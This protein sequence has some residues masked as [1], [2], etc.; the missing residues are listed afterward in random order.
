MVRPHRKACQSN[1]HSLPSCTEPPQKTL[2]QNREVV[3][4][5]SFG[6]LYFWMYF[7]VIMFCGDLTWILKTKLVNLFVW[8]WVHVHKTFIYLG[9][10][11]RWIRK[12]DCQTDSSQIGASTP[13]STFSWTA[14]EKKEEEGSE[15]KRERNNFVSFQWGKTWAKSWY[16][17][18]WK[19]QQY[20][21]S[22]H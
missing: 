11:W 8:F 1:L 14:R 7:W 18:P 17:I 15:R 22:L 4:S 12:P 9:R 13:D 16:K 5:V 6:Y 19:I 20:S 10:C 21:V 2:Q 3:I